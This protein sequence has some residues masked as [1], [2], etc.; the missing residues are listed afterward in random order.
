MIFGCDM[1]PGKLSPEQDDLLRTR[2]VEIIDMRH[3]LV[4]LAALIDWEVFAQAS[5]GLINLRRAFRLSMKPS[6]RG[7]QRTHTGS[8][9]AVRHSFSTVCQSTFRQ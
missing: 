1:N 5:A 7:R 2:L 3:K 6:W 4:K 8:T 9:S